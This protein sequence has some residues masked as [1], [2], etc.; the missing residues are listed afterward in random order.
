MD[1]DSKTQF[2][3][4]GIVVAFAIVVGGLWLWLRPKSGTEPI[5]P[6]NTP[7]ASEP[8]PFYPCEPGEKCA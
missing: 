3:A 2:K 7:P 8:I 1:N 6:K 5:V 4:L